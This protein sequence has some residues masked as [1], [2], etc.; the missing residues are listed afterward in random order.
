MTVAREAQNVPIRIDP[1][2]KEVAD[3]ALRLM[4]LLERPESVP[5]LQVQLVRE[6]HYWL[7]SGR[8]GAAIRQLG[9]RD[10]HAQR[11]A[12]AVALIREDYA[13]PLRVERLAE[14]AR[15]SISSFHHHF[16][17]VTTL[18][19]L[20]FQKQLRLIEAQ[21]LMLAEGVLASHAAYSVGY[22]SVPQ[23]TREYGRMFGVSPVKHIRAAKDGVA[24]VA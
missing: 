14:V 24:A 15:M 9:S 5:V 16:R 22:E 10:S 17:A 23:F 6:M 7:L 11:I 2:D 12:R 1:T 18:S 4:R 3:T 20:Q 13:K 8:H 21:R 19:P